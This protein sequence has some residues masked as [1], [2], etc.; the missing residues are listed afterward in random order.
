MASFKSKFTIFLV[1][2]AFSAVA[3]AERPQAGPAD[4]PLHNWSAPRTYTLPAVSGAHPLSIQSGELTGGPLTFFPVAPC[5][6]FDSRPS[7]GGPGALI[8]NATLTVNLSGAP[9][10][11]F[12]P[13]GASAVSVNITV[14]DILSA[15][16][17]GVF[18]VGTA[19]PPTTAWIN[20]PPSETQRANAGV[21]P[22]NSSGNITV[23]VNQGAGSVDFT[24]DVNGYYYNGT[25]GS[26]MPTGDFFEIRGDFTGGGVFV[27][28]NYQSTGAFSFGA[29]GL[30]ES[31]GFFSAGVEGEDST[32]LGSTSGVL[33]IDGSTGFMSGFSPGPEGVTGVNA[34]SGVL[35]IAQDRSVVGVLIDP[36]T[37]GLD[38]AEGWLGKSGPTTGSYTGVEGVLFGGSASGGAAGVLGLDNTGDPGINSV[39]LTAGVMGRT[40]GSYGVLGISNDAGFAVKGTSVNTSGF[41]AAAGYLGFSNITGVFASGNLTA[42]GTKSFIDPHPT[43]A[44]KVIAYVALEGPEAG[45]YFRGRGR[46]ENG[47]AT[48]Q[49]PENFRMVGDADGMTVQVT[50][51][52]KMANV[53]VLSFDLNQIVVQANADVEFFYTV[54]GMR[55]AFKDY[56]PIQDN[57]Y[58]GREGSTERMSTALAPEQ[59]ARLIANGTYNADGTINL[60][61]AKRL[62]WDKV[63]EA[64]AEAAKETAEAR[65][66]QSSDRSK[67]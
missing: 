13:L 63:W 29:R 25:S 43:D 46:F 42:T 49:V 41:Q 51:I 2:L 33:G 56:T 67:K 24:V 28:H 54:N 53:A 27:G 21:V 23:Q 52:G 48:I 12:T 50:P 1:L 47:M 16:G 38:I 22:T 18:K 59:K 37:A 40:N 19:S 6:Q 7:H 3:V 55:K 11:M 5:R 31:T 15:T 26:L 10:N 57:I 66:A 32:G 20:Y 9:C 45:I 35:G 39:G 44:S 60:E 14:F 58:F 8:N 62:G 61:T 17:N 65:A 4:P 64:R 34:F 36:A 30:T